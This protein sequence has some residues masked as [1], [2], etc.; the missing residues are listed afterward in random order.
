MIN[1][2]NL[3]PFPKFCYTIGMIPTSYKE[4][5][6]YEEQL[7]WFCDFLENT[8]IPTV[9]NNGMAV[10]ELQNLYI[11]LKN[12]VD[13]YFDN[14][15]IQVE[16]NNKLDKMAQ[17]GTL[18]EIISSYLNSKAL[19]GYDN[20]NDMKNATN[21]I[22]GSFVETLGYY[23]ANDGGG[24]T[25]L[26]RERKETDIEDLGS[27]HFINDTLVAE[28]I[29]NQTIN[30]LQV[31]AIPEDTTKGLHNINV[32]KNAIDKD[33][34]IDLAG[35]TFYIETT[36]TIPITKN[37]L[38]KNGKLIIG[39]GTTATSIFKSTARIDLNIDNVEIESLINGITFYMYELNPNIIK[40]MDSYF[41]GNLSLIRTCYVSG[42][43]TPIIDTPIKQIIFTRNKC[44]NIGMSFI[45]I[46]DT[47]YDYCEI[48]NNEIHNFSY[49]FCNNG[50]DNAYEYGDNIAVN[51]KE[52]IVKGNYVHNDID[53]N[54]II[55]TS[56]YFCFILTE[57]NICIYEGNHVEGL[58]TTSNVTCVDGY[59]SSKKVYYRNNINK[60][61]L[62]ITEELNQS[63]F[64]K[65][66]GGKDNNLGYGIKYCENNKFII[67]REYA[68]KLNVDINLLKIA[69][70]QATTEQKLYF[71]NNIVE[72]Y[73]LVVSYSTANSLFKEL[74]FVN[75]KISCYKTGIE[76][77]VENNVNFFNPSNSDNINISN[78]EFNVENSSGFNFIYCNDKTINKLTINNNI[79][80]GNM[81]SFLTR[82]VSDL[83]ICKD[84]VVYSQT[85]AEKNV[86]P[87]FGLKCNKTI[88]ERNTVYQENGMNRLN[89][90]LYLLNNS[91]FNARYITP[92]KS[93]FLTENLTKIGNQTY[94]YEMI[95]K[96]KNKTYKGSWYIKGTVE[97]ET[98]KLFVIPS[99]E[100]EER[101]VVAGEWVNVKM[102]D[103]EN[104]NEILIPQIGGTNKVIGWT[105][106]SGY[107]AGTILDI[108]LTIKTI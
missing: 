5:L 28:L 91:L 43:S 59:F 36:E 52:M 32:I 33:L 15:D 31:G 85:S 69:L 97:N 58:H 86:Y 60:N 82:V 55:T 14:L 37:L 40:V 70:L 19:F 81:L 42:E 10:E 93:S 3:K 51:M 49:V 66:K 7:W 76:Y 65:A 11:E 72:A 77:N 44:E 107:V 29:K 87:F 9:N 73:S 102:Q 78:N 2:E 75:N 84:N 96:T 38:I 24:A 104:L 68:T 1:V 48:S 23:S 22:N 13:T 79:I 100:T 54:P 92:F 16:I 105:I 64:F 80:K 17:D 89:P 103:G 6:T 99:N 46:N 30:I 67:E 41:K 88:I 94:Y 56:Q 47:K 27:I 8:V 83:V 74:E 25:Y 45:K 20:V 62:S 90:F 101:E 18:Q 63:Y 4:S 106:K 34:I 95:V 26:I 61:N 71:R 108:E 50:I 57:G 98:Q 21:L 35:K 12:Y 39:T 53:Y